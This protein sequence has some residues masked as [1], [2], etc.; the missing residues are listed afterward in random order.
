MVPV[1]G[2][3]DSLPVSHQQFPVDQPA[4][5]RS[6]DASSEI[7]VDLSEL[8]VHRHAVQANDH[9]E[10]VHHMFQVN[11]AGY[12]AVLEGNSVVGLCSRRE[13][14][15]EL[16]SQ[17]GFALFA[18]HAVREHLVSAPLIVSADDDWQLLLRRVFSRVDDSFSE[19]V[20]L[21]DRS[22][23][24]LGLITVEALIR[25][26]TRLL[27]QAVERMR[28]QRS[29]IERKNR[30]MMS[31]LAV[32]REIQRAL[33]PTDFTNICS[34][35]SGAGHAV[36]IFAHY[37]PKDSVSGDFFEVLALSPS[38]LSVFVA[39]VMGH[40][41]QA[42]L[43]TAMLRVLVQEH[44]SL[45][46]DPAALLDAI[47][48]SLCA[49]LGDIRD[50]VFVSAFA[51]ALDVSG[52]RLLYANAG[53]PSPLLLRAEGAAYLDCSETLNGGVLG[54][55]PAGRYRN[56]KASLNAGDRLLVYTDGLFEIVDA[57]GTQLGQEGLFAAAVER[58]MLSG[59]RLVNDLLCHARQHAAER[60]FT[61]DVCLVLVE[62][63]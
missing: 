2:M 29:E 53:H 34:Q 27:T 55:R 46:G 61:D 14:A 24:L 10:Q 16:G 50:P 25:L 12:M 28:Q 15:M 21:T 56:A 35:V 26:Q 6:A 47:N 18:R 8:I 33:Q 20:V 37:E 11:D 13:I 32:A 38:T 51:A 54:I 7:H 59:E 60:R 45:A 1:L 22:G 9:L 58:R 36:R 30:L 57:G 40:G 19:D 39:D 48:G 23:A 31:E 5:F 17:Y 52:S 42:A 4:E 63:R 49:I 62:L 43:V 41:V 44:S 3:Q